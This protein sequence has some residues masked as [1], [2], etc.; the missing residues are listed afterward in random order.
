M[1]DQIN[2]FHKK[3]AGLTINSPHVHDSIIHF[4][5]LKQ[6]AKIQ[7]YLMCNKIGGCFLIAAFMPLLSARDPQIRLY[8][9]FAKAE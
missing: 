8:S 7:M 1:C 2:I 9:L 4:F 6:G 3:K 5:S